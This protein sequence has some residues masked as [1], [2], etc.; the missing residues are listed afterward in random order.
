VRLALRFAVRC[1]EDV[2]R[3]L[4][5]ALCRDEEV[6]LALWQSPE[7]WAGVRQQLLPDAKPVRSDEV[8]EAQAQHQ[9]FVRRVVV[10]ILRQLC[11]PG[12]H[13]GPGQGGLRPVPVR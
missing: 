10:R 4:Q 11:D 12:E 5:L 3:D 7:V 1:R 9:L 2:Q 6:R 8:L 13:A